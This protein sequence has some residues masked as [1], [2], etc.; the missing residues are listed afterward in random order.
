MKPNRLFHVVPS[1]YSQIARIALAEKC[2]P[3][4]EEITIA[5]PPVY[6]NYQPEY[7]RMN[8]NGV[9]P[10][11]VHGDRIVY[12]AVDIARYVDEHFEGPSLSPSDPNE[13]AEMNRW[14]DRITELPIRVMSYAGLTGIGGRIANAANQKRLSALAR[15]RDRNPDLKDVYDAKIKDIEEFVRDIITPEA[16]NEVRRKSYRYLDELDEIFSRRDWIVGSSYS[17]ADAVWTVLIARMLMLKLDP[18]KGRPHV[19]A[20]YERVKARPSFEN[21]SI[22]EEFQPYS[23]FEMIAKRLGPA[24]AG[25]GL[26]I[27]VLVLAID[28][29]LHVR[30]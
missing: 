26:A 22:W 12:E 11:F 5:G 19:A 13:K 18:L 29:I 27:T 17:L 30:G 8:P 16:V 1:F 9:I 2:V 3:F 4:Q 7:L 23:M 24:L 14:I 20:F 21:A 25:L 6:D 10:T 28:W 15:L